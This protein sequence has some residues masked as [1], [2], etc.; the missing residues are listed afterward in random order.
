MEPGTVSENDAKGTFSNLRS[1]YYWIKTTLEGPRKSTIWSLIYIFVNIGFLLTTES[2]SIFILPL[3]FVFAF[4]ALIIIPGA[5][6]SALLVKVKLHSLGMTILFGILFQCLLIQSMFN[7]LLIFGVSAPLTLWL[8]IFNSLIAVVGMQIIPRLRKSLGVS[9]LN[10][11][12]IGL[13]FLVVS[14][15]FIIRFGMFI[16]AGDALAPDAAFYADYARNVLDGTFQSNTLG[17]TRIYELWDGYQY[18]FHQAFTYIFAISMLLYPPLGGGP[19]FILILIGT[20]LIPVVMSLTTTY[21]GQKEGVWI[22]RILSLHPLFIFHS[23]VGYGPEI[24][25]LLFIMGGLLLILSAEKNQS[26]ALLIGGIMLGIADVIWY[27]NFL[28]ILV[29]LPLFLIITRERNNPQILYF[30][31]LAF[32]ALLLRAFYSNILA[33]FLIILAQILAYCFLRFLK[34]EWNAHNLT[35][36]FVGINLVILFWRWPILFLNTSGMSILS[37]SASALLLQVPNPDFRVF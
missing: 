36:C 18:S 20:A 28:I 13:P 15:A 34:Q 21:F 17:D 1:I 26:S 16:I 14:V 11:K 25:S 4:L 19:T 31:I 33:V 3:R 7:I 9:V 37:E 32:S 2:D 29:A 5:I 24:S 35:W 23:A 6:L 30:G 8:V 10:T 12:G 22:S 27:T